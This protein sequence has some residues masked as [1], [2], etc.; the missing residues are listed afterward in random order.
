MYKVILISFYSTQ[1]NHL[2]LSLSPPNTQA[3]KY[4][5]VRQNLKHT[6]L[7]GTELVSLGPQLNGIIVE[8]LN[9]VNLNDA[10][11]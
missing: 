8:T 5:K 7:K 1:L 3:V 11:T 4:A 2:K 6:G 10:G 9:S